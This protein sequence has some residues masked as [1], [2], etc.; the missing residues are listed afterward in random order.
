MSLNTPSDYVYEMYVRL[1]DSTLKY[2]AD[3]DLIER[4]GVTYMSA[5]LNDGLWNIAEDRHCGKGY[6]SWD[7]M[8]DDLSELVGS[9][10]LASKILNKAQ[11]GLNV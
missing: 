11:G 5:K 2:I 9:E 8:L 10:D 7:G 1:Y 6:F 3:A 4:L